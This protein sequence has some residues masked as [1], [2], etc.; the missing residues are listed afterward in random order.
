M[1]I[2]V[3]KKFVVRQR[4][5][6]DEVPSPERVRARKPIS[7]GMP[8]SRESSSEFS[9]QRIPR[10]NRFILHSFSL[11]HPGPS[12][13]RCFPF[14]LL[15]AIQPVPRPQ[16]VSHR[17]SSFCFFLWLRGHPK[18]TSSPTRGETLQDAWLKPP[19]MALVQLTKWAERGVPRPRDFTRARYGSSEFLLGRA[20]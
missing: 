1:R 18:A 14:R 12:A 11:F 8:P 7:S 13:T 17:P 9:S 20:S 10:R 5:E 16:L 4:S 19:P 3:P 6:S 2:W 15:L